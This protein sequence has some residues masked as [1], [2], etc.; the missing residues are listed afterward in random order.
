MPVVE[1]VARQH[2]L[3]DDLAWCQIAHQAL[4]AGMTEGTIERAADLA[5]NAQR[6][7][8]GLRNVDAFDFM[9]PGVGLARQP[10]QPFSRAVD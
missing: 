9:R 4:R 1:V 3:A 10:Q 8:V 6:A 5:G 7:T 2:N